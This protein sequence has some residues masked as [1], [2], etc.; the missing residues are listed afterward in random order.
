MA[1]NK[2]RPA[3]TVAI[4]DDH[5]IVHAGVEAW[6]AQAD[7]PIRLVGSYLHPKDFW[8]AIPMCPTTWTSSCSTRR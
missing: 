7:P 3:V 4:I 8:P 1:S 2:A 6:C 5:D